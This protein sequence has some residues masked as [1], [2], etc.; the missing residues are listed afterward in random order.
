MWRVVIFPG[1]PRHTAP[2]ARSRS[3]RLRAPECVAPG[4]HG[5][6]AHDATQD[7]ASLRRR[8]G[9]GT[10]GPH[11]PGPG[12]RPGGASGEGGA[13]R[14]GG[15]GR[16]GVVASG[17]HGVRGPLDGGRPGGVDRVPVAGARPATA[18]GHRVRHAGGHR[19]C[20]G[21]RQRHDRDG[22]GP[23]GGG[24]GRQLAATG[25]PGRLRRHRGALRPHR[26][27]R[28]RHGVRGP[29]RRGRL[30][31]PGGIAVNALPTS[32]SPSSAT[33]WPRR[34]V[35]PGRTCSPHTCCAR[36]GCTARPCGPAV[37]GRT[38]SATPRAA[39]RR[40]PPSTPGASPPRARCGPPRTTC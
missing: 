21:P 6:D 9:R 26:P 16:G 13:G 40:S 36:C 29:G 19:G 34:W 3:R 14:V 32:A 38:P 35:P 22:P 23:P 8:R 2:G 30:R 1:D 7:P 18:G 15:L 28:L 24:P 12:A 10:A 25:Q 11:G 20:A 27:E 4:G 31:G 17:A 37:L 5:M 33:R 39:R